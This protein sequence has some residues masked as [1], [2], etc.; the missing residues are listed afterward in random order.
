VTADE[1]IACLGLRPLPI[2]GG[3]YR[4]TF[5][6]DEQ[7]AAPGLPA[8]YPGARS[9]STAIYYLLT[10]DT[11]SA[12]HRLRSDEIYH[13]YL[14]DPVE[15]LL[16]FP[17]GRGERHRLGTDLR[18]GERPQLLAPR[19][20]WQGSRLLPGGRVALLGTTVSPGFE[21]A[22]FEAGA[23]AQL[24]VAYPSFRAEIEALSP[25]G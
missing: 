19:G 23:R 24:L 14:G 11:C 13:F 16:L 2:E 1:I 6:A 10:P 9:L 4:E 5:R 8:R 15:L 12:L 18:A 3:Y 7:L 25:A 21:L 22:D 20:A 17:D